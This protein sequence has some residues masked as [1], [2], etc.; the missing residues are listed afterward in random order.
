M[1]YY[2]KYVNRID[3]LNMAYELSR[4]TSILILISALA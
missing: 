3:V 1:L 2:E 4:D